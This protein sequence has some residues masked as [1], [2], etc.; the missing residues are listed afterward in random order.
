MTVESSEPFSCTPSPNGPG[1]RQRPSLGPTLDLWKNSEGRLG[2]R[3]VGVVYRWYAIAGKRRYMVEEAT[4]SAA[5]GGTSCSM[6]GQILRLHLQPI[7]AISPRLPCVLPY[8]PCIRVLGSPAAY[9]EAMHLA[10]CNPICRPSTHTT[11]RC[12]SELASRWTKWRLAFALEN[13]ETPGLLGAGWTVHQRGWTCAAARGTLGLQLYHPTTL[14][15]PCSW[16][17]CVQAVGRRAYQ[18]GARRR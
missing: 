5:I 10:N 12:A 1:G 11:L 3:L 8:L 16:N 2:A 9:H 4:R 14:P 17:G 7:A 18:R 15:A 13:V 6:E